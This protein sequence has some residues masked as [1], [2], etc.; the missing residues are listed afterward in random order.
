MSEDKILSDLS[1]SSPAIFSLRAI[2]QRIPQLL[3]GVLTVIDASI[4]E[5][6]ARKATKDLVKKY[7]Y[8]WADE[9]EMHAK[10]VDPEVHGK[11]GGS[12]N[13]E[14]EA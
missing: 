4:H 14:E 6:I 11:M 1:H 5:P 3:G 7:F 8:S 9:L 10:I 13:L 12:L 2:T